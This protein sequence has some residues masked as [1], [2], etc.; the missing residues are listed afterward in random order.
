MLNYDEVWSDRGGVYCNAGFYELP[1][2]PDRRSIESIIS[3]KR[4]M[5]KKR[6]ELL[7][8]IEKKV[9]SDI[10]SMNAGHLGNVIG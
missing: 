9:F 7:N 5:Y 6:Y 4:S 10:N 3:K 2:N 8:L 1:V